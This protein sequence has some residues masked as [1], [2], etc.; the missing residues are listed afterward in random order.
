METDPL[1]SLWVKQATTEITAISPSFLT[2][3]TE[4]KDHK[5][6]TYLSPWKSQKQ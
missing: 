5:V 2:R 3:N 4:Y 6:S 1:A